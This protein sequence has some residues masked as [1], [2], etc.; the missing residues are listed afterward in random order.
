MLT[1]NHA[2]HPSIDPEVRL[3]LIKLCESTVKPQPEPLMKVR[4]P[5]RQSIV[6]ESPAPTPGPTLPKL[7]LTSSHGAGTAPLPKITLLSRREQSLV[8][9]CRLSLTL[10]LSTTASASPMPAAVEPEPEYFPEQYDQSQQAY[11]QGDPLPYEPPVPAPKKLKLKGV[12][13]WRERGMELSDYTVCKNVHGKV[14]KSKHAPMFR[15]AVGWS[16]SLE[17]VAAQSF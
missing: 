9:F 2:S 12:E 13:G 5:A 11:D 14:F 15:Y 1:S 3:C 10:R 4:I 16:S 7:K 6:G 8:R 17:I